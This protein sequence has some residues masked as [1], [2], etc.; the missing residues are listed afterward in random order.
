MCLFTIDPTSNPIKT[1]F[2]IS[3]KQ[4][5]NV[6]TQE[7]YLPICNLLVIYKQSYSKPNL[8]TTKYVT[9]MFKCIYIS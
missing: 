1:C 6:I 7:L 8:S 2:N 3:L 4:N 9:T 5:C